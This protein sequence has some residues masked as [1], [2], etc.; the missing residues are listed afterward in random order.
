MSR[1]WAAVVGTVFVVALVLHACVD[2]GPGSDFDHDGLKDSVEDPDDDF[3]FDPGETDLVSPDTDRD[4]VCDGRPEPPLA[5]CTGCED[6]NG[7]GFWEPCLGETDP[8]NDDTDNDGMPDNT[9]PAPLDRL[10]IDCGQGDVQLPYGASLPS[11]KPFPVRPT[12]TPSPAPFPTLPPGPAP[13]PV[14][15]PSGV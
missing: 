12:A 15:T 3:V 11:G 9:D 8:L 7:N 14:S 13:T 6:C 2:S 4:G 10:T 5:S 1:T